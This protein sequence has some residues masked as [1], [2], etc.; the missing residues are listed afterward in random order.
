MTVSSKLLHRK[1]SLQ[2]TK[3]FN[4]SGIGQNPQT[5]N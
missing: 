5:F 1:H 4:Q 3:Y 2:Y